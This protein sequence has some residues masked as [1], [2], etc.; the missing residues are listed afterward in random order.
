MAGYHNAKRK[1]T[2]TI[3]QPVITKEAVVGKENGSN[4]ID[5]RIEINPSGVDLLNGQEGKI[6]ILDELGDGLIL[7]EDSI[8]L[9]EA[10]A[11]N[12][13]GSL[14]LSKGQLETDTQISVDS[15]YHT[16]TVILPKSNQPYILTYTT[17]ATRLK[18]LSNCASLQG[19]QAWEQDWQSLEASTLTNISNAG[20][21]GTLPPKNMYVSLCMQ[22]VDQ[23]SGKPLS[24]AEIGLYL[25]EYDETSMLTSGITDESGLC[26]LSVKKKLLQNADMLYYKELNAPDGYQQDVHWYGISIDEIQDTPIRFEN[27]QM[28]QGREAHI[29]LEVRDVLTQEPVPMAEFALYKYK[30]DISPFEVRQTNVFGTITFDNLVP[31]HPYFIRL[32][33]M[34][35]EYY[36]NIEENF[37]QAYMDEDNIVEIPAQIAPNG[38][39]G[40]GDDGE[41]N[42]PEGGGGEETQPDGGEDGEQ[43]PSN[44]ENKNPSDEENSGEVPSSSHG[45]Q[46]STEEGASGELPPSVGSNSSEET[47]SSI[48]ATQPPP[49]D[50]AKTEISD[51]GDR[52]DLT[53]KTESTIPK[54]GIAHWKYI[55]IAGMV[56]SATMSALLAMLYFK[57]WKDDGKGGLK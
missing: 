27:E 6:W 25:N 20:G 38:G 45:D 54:T 1:K 52:I 24:G 53:S 47:T 26:V 39:D 50:T 32:V 19:V 33:D 48:D 29:I 16:F 40:G 15:V 46:S 41:Q 18:N 31:G 43:N 49:S 5:Y 7:N 12:Q 51:S 3:D 22:K 36:L 35:E 2:V 34:P 9:Y 17:Y 56:L 21:G 42:P 4:K 44:D 37:V 10:S 23:T 8:Q 28:E 14:V 30:E 11:N 57:R 55:L 13:N